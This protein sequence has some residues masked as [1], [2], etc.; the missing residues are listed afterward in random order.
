M[1]AVLDAVLTSG[2]MVLAGRFASS[3][4][5]VS[6]RLSGR[7][8]DVG[9]LVHAPIM[10]VCPVQCYVLCMLLIG[11]PGRTACLL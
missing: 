4:I 11:C 1:I 10:E 6:V 7:I 8:D 2:G 5:A 9:C 3:L